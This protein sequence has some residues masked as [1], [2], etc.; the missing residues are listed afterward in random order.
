M[1]TDHKRPMADRLLRTFSSLRTGIVL[2]ILLVIASA[3]GTMVLQ[4]PIT[5]P[6][7]LTRAYSPQ[8]LVWLDRLG[9]T[10]VFHSW[11]F[12]AL[13]GLLCVNIIFAS[14]ERFPGVWRQI[15][16]PYRRP[17]AHFLSGLPLHEEIPLR[18]ARQGVEAAERAFRR[19]G[20]RPQL[21]GGEKDASLFA[22]RHRIARLAAYVVHLS[23]L[24]ILIGGMVDGIWGYRGFV[25]LTQNEEVNQIELRDGTVIA[26]PFS[27]HCY[28]A[29][30]ENYPDGSPRRW[31]SK[32]AVV[33]DGREVKTEEIEV[34]KPLVHRGLRFFQSS[35]GTTGDAGAIHLTAQPKEGG[36]A[37][38][39]TLVQGENVKL[40]AET[41]VHLSSFVPDFVLSNGQIAT[42]SNQPNNPA[43]QLC[44][45]RQGKESK[46]WL[47]PKFP[48]FEHPN[49][50]PYQFTFR[51][52]DMGYFTGLQVAYEPGQWA[53]WTGVVL[54]GVGLLMAFYMVHMRFWAVPVD[55]GRGRLVLWVGANASKSREESR[56]RFERLVKAIQAELDGHAEGAEYAPAAR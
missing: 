30:Q 7:Q 9:L 22:E 10:D 24:L 1:T 42:R 55:D 25:A 44:I 27:I 54:M 37:K 6:E 13:M 52:F 36:A 23:L 20:L 51:D 12:V 28:G 35:Y 43:I 46:V 45:E 21:V 29:G 18:D 17:E 4:R 2:L 53:V 56:E 34:N 32:L 47:F 8:T 16:R 5:D 11:W 38:E 41:S 26:L 40:D 50:A 49:E 19:L 31:W 15:V 39:I 33:E 14:L 3:A 48:N